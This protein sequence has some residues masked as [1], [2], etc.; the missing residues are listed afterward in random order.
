ML[1]KLVSH[2]EPPATYYWGQANA[3][4]PLRKSTCY[5]LLSDQLRLTIYVVVPAAT[6]TTHD[7]AYR[8]F[9]FSGDLGVA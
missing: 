4:E 2:V 5:L 6:Q 3:V 8:Y 7:S 1:M 9:Q